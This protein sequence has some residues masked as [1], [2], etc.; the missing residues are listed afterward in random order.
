VWRP[1]CAGIH[2]RSSLAVSL[3][4]SCSSLARPRRHARHVSPIIPPSSRASRNF[5]RKRCFVRIIRPWSSSCTTT[6]VVR[7][8]NDMTGTQTHVGTTGYG[9]TFVIRGPV[10]TRPGRGHR[11]LVP[12]TPFSRTGPRTS[13]KT[14]AFNAVRVPVA[15]S[16]SLLAVRRNPH[17]CGRRPI[18]N[19]KR[20]RQRVSTG[21]YNN[22]LAPR[23]L[24]ADGPPPPPPLPNPVREIWTKLV[25]YGRPFGPQSLHYILLLLLHS[26][27]DFVYWQNNNGA[28]FGKWTPLCSFEE[29]KIN[30]IYGAGDA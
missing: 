1:S 4:R 6:A 30:F 27:I 19:R 10:T 22:T 29:K 21:E 15:P 26:C 13:S 5:V 3:A 28:V 8:G 23:V 24:L 2:L 25:R 12:P 18:L 7:R 9:R 14:V 20:F 17:G 11:A 16:R